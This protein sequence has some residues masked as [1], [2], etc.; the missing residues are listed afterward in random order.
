MFPR[1]INVVIG[2]GIRGFGDTKWMFISQVF[3]T[4]YVVG[5]AAIFIFGLRSGIFGLYLAFFIDELTRSIINLIRFYKGRE[6]F[7]RLVAWKSLSN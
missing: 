1:D 2:H 3:G 7:L 6:F 5:L 4:I